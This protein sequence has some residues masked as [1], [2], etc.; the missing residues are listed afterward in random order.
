MSHDNAEIIR[1]V[2]DRWNAGDLSG[3]L[4][5][6]HP[7]VEVLLSGVWMDIPVPYQGYD[8]LGEF[9]TTFRQA[10]LEYSTSD[11]AVICRG[12]ELKPPGGSAPGRT[13]DPLFG[14]GPRAC[15]ARADARR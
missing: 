2:A 4:E 5:L 11:S 8:G 1:R 3:L 13:R 9:M 7:D 15:R 6:V 12:R 10:W 14:G